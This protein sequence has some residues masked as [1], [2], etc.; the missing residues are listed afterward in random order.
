MK[1][2]VASIH[3]AASLMIA[4]SALA[5]DM[6]P[7]AKALN[8]TAC[9]SLETKMLGPTFRDISKAYNKVGATGTAVD[10]VAYKFSY[11]VSDILAKNNAR[12]PA[13]WLLHKTSKGGSGNWG[14]MPMPANDP[15][16]AKQTEIK[17]LIKFIL[18]LEK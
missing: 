12:S 17:E 5:A 18:N 8:C 13:E 10:P 3:I 9:H 4:G 16:G 7:M 14:T 6:P 11:K 2:I 1:H 15:V